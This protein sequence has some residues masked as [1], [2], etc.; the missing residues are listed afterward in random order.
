[1]RNF[2]LEK[3]IECDLCQFWY[4]FECVKQVKFLLARSKNPMLKIKT[5]GNQFLFFVD[6]LTLFQTD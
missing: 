3:C 6:K 1:M 4:N 2:C 5:Y